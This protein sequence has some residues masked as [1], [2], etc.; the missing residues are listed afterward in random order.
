MELDWRGLLKLNQDQVMGLDIGSS[1]VKMV[2][3]RKDDFGWLVTSAGI[4]DIAHD[5][6]KKDADETNTVRAIRE[7][8]R[9]SAIK[10]RLAVCSVCGPEVAVRHFRFPALP[11]AEIAGAVLLEAEQV[12]PFN[13]SDAS[14]DYHLIP[15]GQNNVSGI[16][17]AATN[18]LIKRKKR[19]T[20]GAYL[21][22]VLMDV[23]GLAL[24]N[25]FKQFASCTKSKNS[26]AGECEENKAGQTIAILNVGS[27]F[28]NLAIIGND[29]LPFIRD[30]AYAGNDIVKQIA[31]ENNVRPE[32]V[33]KILSGCEV[34]GQAPLEL[35]DS[36][37]KA[38]QK[39]IVD[40]AETLRYY[41]SQKVSPVV[42]NIFVCGGFALVKG[43]VELLDNMLS[44]RAVLWNPF[45]KI[46]C[47]SGR[48]CENLLAKNGPAMAVAAGLAMRSI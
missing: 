12:C 26:P 22:T 19:L 42:E 36:L 13:I 41:T 37:T 9:S 18:K 40:V 46:R 1:A 38:C 14:V 11:D 2:Q 15:D 25:C 23:D 20:E 21:S 6:D 43:F 34:P 10:S 16:L 29:G 45:D 8:L 32:I 4:V 7:C 27:S 48:M 35:G 5:Q 17:V 31:L 39:L 44:A 24:L 30:M 33:G 3:M 47:E 28:T